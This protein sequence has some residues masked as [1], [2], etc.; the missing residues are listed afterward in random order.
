MK[1]GTPPPTRRPRPVG[2][3]FVAILLLLLLPVLRPGYGASIFTGPVSSIPGSGVTVNGAGITFGVQTVNTASPTG[4]LFD[5]TTGALTNIAA[6]QSAGNNTS[7]VVANGSTSKPTSGYG[8]L[9][10][11][12]SGFPVNVDGGISAPSGVLTSSQI[13]ASHAPGSGFGGLTGGSSSLYTALSPGAVPSASAGTGASNFY[14][15]PSAVA[16]TGPSANTASE[17]FSRA[18]STYQVN[19]LPAVKVPG[20]VLAVS[21]SLGSQGPSG[22][23]VAASL[24]TTFSFFTSLGASIPTL[25][26]ETASILI[27]SNG[28]GSRS[29]FVAAESSNS[30]F[31][32]FGAVYVNTGSGG[33]AADSFYAAGII[34]LPSVTLA[35]GDYVKIDSTLSLVADPDATV[36]LDAFP[37]SL[38]NLTPDLAAEAFT[39]P[40]PSSYVIFATG[41]LGV[42][43]ALWRGRRSRQ[44]GS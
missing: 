35:I 39:V 12:G 28:T 23:F 8:S 3:P 29:N 9:G 11:S 22:A 25:P 43:G 26:T 32:P 5:P 18:I 17:V 41:T 30:S 24:Q 44:S 36:M 38:I 6:L 40:E 21:G 42:L 27:V 4:A 2:R 15:A 37:T 14:L 19:A 34:D 1:H 20:V 10:A 33:A 13:S 16:D 31:G 7:F